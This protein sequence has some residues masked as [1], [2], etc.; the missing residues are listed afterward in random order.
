MS[1]TND[2]RECTVEDPYKKIEGVRWCHPQAE[3]VEGTCECCAAYKC[4][5]CG[6]TFKEELPE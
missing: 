3:D 1:S 2:R 4:P 6:L 5:V